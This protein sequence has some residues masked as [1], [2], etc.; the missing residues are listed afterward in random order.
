[1]EEFRTLERYPNYKISKAG[2]LVR[3]SYKKISTNI[4]GEYECNKR[5]LEIKFH[6]VPKGY[7][8][9]CLQIGDGQI[10]CFKHRLLAETWVDNP[11]KKQFVNHKDGNKL[12]NDLSNLEWVTA[13]E[14]TIHAYD[15]GLMFYKRST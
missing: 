5:E 9:C 3:K 11:E 6:K 1:M 15:L 14:N 8:R 2:K 13:S 4:Y 10:K 7:L 12:N